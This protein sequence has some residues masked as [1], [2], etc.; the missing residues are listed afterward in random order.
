MCSIG[1]AIAGGLG[2]GKAAIDTKRAMA[3]QEAA[4][5]QN[6]AKYNEAVAQR[7][8]AIAQT[9]DEAEIRSKEAVLQYMQLDQA[10]QEAS[11]S[12]AVEKG[13]IAIEAAKARSLAKLGA[14]ESGVSGNSVDRIMNDIGVQRMTQT[15]IVEQSRANQ[16]LQA[17]T[18][19]E[20]VTL[21]AH[22]S[23]VYSYIGDAPVKGRSG[24]T[25][26]SGLISAGASSVEAI[27]NYAPRT[28]SQYKFLMG[29]G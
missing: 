25:I 11:E 10:Q 2:V 17:Q 28:S 23:P 24:L 22:T 15:G 27:R 3:E 14:L 20:A 16:V 13:Q 18:E 21:R 29:K 9:R 12:A 19:K 4:Y 1:S 6:L 26:A 8:I 5:Q 7:D